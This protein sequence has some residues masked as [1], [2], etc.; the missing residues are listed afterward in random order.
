[1]E[2]EAAAAVDRA[3]RHVHGEGAP[4]RH[5]GVVAVGADESLLMK[6]AVALIGLQ[7]PGTAEHHVLLLC[8][9]LWERTTADVWRQIMKV[10]LNL[11][12]CG[13]VKVKVRVES[14]HLLRR[15]D[16]DGR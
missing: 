11:S 13:A 12:V 14:C 10:L 4:Q 2:Q 6:D 8:R 16:S 3:H 15:L 7:H 9:R 5:Q 1:M